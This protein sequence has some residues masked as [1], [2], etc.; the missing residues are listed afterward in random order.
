MVT[1]RDVSEGEPRDFVFRSFCTSCS[2]NAFNRLSKVVFEKALEQDREKVVTMTR[3]YLMS[4]TR[5]PE[6]IY[7]AYFNVEL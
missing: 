5:R 4:K 1:G 7:R 2:V 3:D 6:V